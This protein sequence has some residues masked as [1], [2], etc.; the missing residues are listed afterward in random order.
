MRDLWTLELIVFLLLILPLIKPFFRTLRQFSGLG[1][2]YPISLGITVCLFPAYGFRPEC[3]PLLICVVVVNITTLLEHIADRNSAAM[4]NVYNR[5]KPSRPVSAIVA[6][7]ITTGIAVY[8]S[9][10]L[11]T[12]LT[13]DGVRTVALFDERRQARFSLRIY[14]VEQAESKGFMVVVPPIIDSFHAVDKICAEIRKNGFV[15]ATFAREKTPLKAWLKEKFPLL[16]ALKNGTVLEKANQTGRYWEKERLSDIEFIFSNVD[17]IAQTG[18]KTPVFAVGYGAGGSALISAVSSDA[19]IAA[20]PFLKAVVAVE[21]RLWSSFYHEEEPIETPDDLSWFANMRFKADSWFRSRQP[22]KVNRIAGAPVMRKPALFLV[23]DAVLKAKERDGTYIALLNALYASGAAPALLLAGQGM[24]APDYLDYPAVQPLY[25]AAVLGAGKDPGARR[26]SVT[27][28]A[29]AIASFAS[30]FI[31]G[32]VPNEAVP[33]KQEFRT[34]MGENAY[35]EKNQ[36]WN[37]TDVM[38]Y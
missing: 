27:N 29:A 22:K 5:K 4:E 8:F 25:S 21:S 30:F 31:D 14:N 19:F 16:A 1:W 35:I 7:I 36:A 17:G 20:N 32:F 2:F 3:I 26:A 10:A 23:S 6:L 13:G 15:V 37:S 34:G 33:K 24:K 18:N 12:A 38:V 9:P 28:T 11:D